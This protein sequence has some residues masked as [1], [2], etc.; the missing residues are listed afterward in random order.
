MEKDNKE[1]TYKTRLVAE[2]N[3]LKDRYNKLHRI[4]IK[5]DAGTCE[6]TPSCSVDLLKKQALIMREYMNILEIR[7][8][9][10]KIDLEY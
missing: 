6:F 8:Q 3:E 7:A 1:N 2:Y 4:L 5:L 9:V 10:E